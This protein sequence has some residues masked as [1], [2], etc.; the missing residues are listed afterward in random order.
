MRTSKHIFACGLYGSRVNLTL[1]KDLPGE[2]WPSMDRYAESLA[3]EL[4]N[5]VPD[6]WNVKMP[7]PPDRLR[8]PRRLLAA[9]LFS[10]PLWARAQQGDINHIVDHSYG[11]LLFV[12]NPGKT[13]V[14][15]HDV[16]AL[17][18]PGRRFGLSGMAW[19]LA[20][21]GI[22][23]AH[24]IIVDSHYIAREL[25]S[26]LQ[27]PPEHYYYV[28]LAVSPQFH[29]QSPDQ[30]ADL[31][32]RYQGDAT[33]LLLHVGH[34]QPRKN[35]PALLRTIRLL[36]NR[37]LNVKLV[38]VGG[39]P[40]QAQ[41]ALIAELSLEQAVQFAGSVPFAAE[42]SLSAFYGMADVFVFP[43]LYEGFG[44]PVL[45][46]MACRTPVV[47]GDASSLPE[48]VGDAG[49]LA[50]PESPEAIA[51]A[52]ARVINDAELAQSLR[53]KGAARAATFSWTQTA[54][55]A[56]AAYLSVIGLY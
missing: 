2:N 30:V 56:L 14:T 35:M 13:V 28:P 16:A 11:H 29:P 17:H 36:L 39:V 9:R 6:G 49:L 52:I 26:H 37:G 20:W 15:V 5:V 1:F 22:R 40:T 48:V 19:N 55:C 53:I 38:Q 25:Q 27:L 4:P 42:S 32:R 24:H 7:L 50:D 3:A 44:M 54:R 43:S 21:S 12:L 51:A 10:Y 33:H 45:D 46:A 34:T 23:R 18:F 47:A 8:A 31:R 41:Q